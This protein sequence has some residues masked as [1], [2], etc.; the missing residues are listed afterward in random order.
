MLDYQQLFTMALGL[1][2][3]WEITNIEF[4]LEE[5]RLDINL[6]FGPGA[7]FTCPSCGGKEATAFDT[8]IKT[9]RHLNFFQHSTYIH[10][11]IPRVQCE[12]GCSIKQVEI[13]WARPQS[14]FTLLFEAYIMVLAK[15]MP[16]N[17]I[18]KL[19]GEHDTRL[20]R[21][22]KHYVNKARAQENYSE[23]KQIGIDETSTKKGH[24]YISLFI[25]LDKKRLLYATPG[26]DKETITRFVEDFKEHQG[27]EKNIINVSCD[28]S[29]AFIHGVKESL[30]KASI[31]FDRFHIMKIIN[32][33]VDEVR[34]QEVKENENLK[35]TRYLWLKNPAKLKTWQKETI[36][37]LVL[38]NSKT[39]KAYQAKLNFTQLFE[40]PGRDEGEAFL[41][42]W[43][44]WALDTNL[45]PIA[46]VVKTIKNHWHG[47]LN[48]FYSRISNGLVEGINSLIQAAK[49][50]ARGYRSEENLIT[51]CYILAGKLNFQL[52]T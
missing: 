22:L 31:T 19:V 8:T 43:C 44:L 41:R 5:K 30:L 40:Q 38:M 20:W 46:K 37:S 9:W 28:L 51:M 33:A 49:A 15:E 29:P 32:E 16:V 21:I 35:N 47:I 34:R 24:K 6:G 25:D 45:D 7:R 27:N 3:P 48:W 1:D 11:R 42:H 36:E 4:L 52:P 2:K 12:H 10:A 13:P 18:A 39:A 23:V 50:K 17:A 14:G 26:K